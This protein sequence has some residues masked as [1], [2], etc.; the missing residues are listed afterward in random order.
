MLEARASDE[1]CVFGFYYIV[2][3]LED[4][5]SVQF[6][7]CGIPSDFSLST[8]VSNVFNAIRNSEPKWKHYRILSTALTHAQITADQYICKR[9][10]S[11]QRQLHRASSRTASWRNCGFSHG[12][13]NDLRR[14]RIPLGT[15]LHERPTP[16]F[17]FCSLMSSR[18]CTLVNCR[19]IKRTTT[20]RSWHV[21]SRKKVERRGI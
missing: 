17:P 18:I 12:G 1:V 20:N 13:E 11:T 6:G 2:I 3:H 15:A 16:T 7:E 19:T 14:A 21:S 8:F 5:P 4:T 9:Q 10:I